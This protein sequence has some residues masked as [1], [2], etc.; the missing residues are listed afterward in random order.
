MTPEEKNNHY[1]NILAILRQ[2]AYT[3]QQMVQ[4]ILL[5]F[6]NLLKEEKIKTEKSQSYNVADEYSQDK[7]RGLFRRVT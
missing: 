4:E 5:Y 1:H 3:D 2:S 7:F 6:E